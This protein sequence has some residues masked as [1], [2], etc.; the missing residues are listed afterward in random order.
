[1]IDNDKQFKEDFI[2]AWE[3]F[4]EPL[5]EDGTLKFEC[6][7]RLKEHLLKAGSFEYTDEELW[8][9]MNAGKI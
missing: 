7:P 1:M 8:D 9:L 5:F 3:Q 4:M 2:Q 6:S